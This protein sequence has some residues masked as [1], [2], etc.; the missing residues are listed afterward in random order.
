[1]LIETRPSLSF[2]PSDISVCPFVGQSVS[3]PPPPSVRWVVGGDRSPANM[4][5]AADV[6]GFK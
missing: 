5:T 2:S 6:S 3:W 1:M 4:A